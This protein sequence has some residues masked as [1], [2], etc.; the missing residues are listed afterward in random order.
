MVVLV[1]PGLVLLSAV[2]TL[3]VTL[4]KYHNEIVNVFRALLA[5]ASPRVRQQFALPAGMFA[6]ALFLGLLTMPSAP[7]F[8]LAVMAAAAAMGW[9]VAFPRTVRRYGAR[10]LGALAA[11]AALAAVLLPNGYARASAL[12]LSIDVQPLFDAIQSYVPLFFGILAIGGG[13]AIGLAIARFVI[14]SIK[15]AFEGRSL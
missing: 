5:V 1:L 10:A 3:I 8:A 2:V 13:I 7:G 4:Q 11:A 12:S 6:A 9:Y 15:S 14:N